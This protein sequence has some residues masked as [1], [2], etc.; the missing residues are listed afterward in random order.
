MDLLLSGRMMAAQRGSYIVKMKIIDP[1]VSPQ[2]RVT[3]A[4]KNQ[5]ALQVGAGGSSRTRGSLREKAHAALQQAYRR[6]H[7]QTANEATAAAAAA[8]DA[9]SCQTLSL[10]HLVAA[11]WW[12]RRR[13]GW[14]C[15][16][17]AAA[18]FAG[19]A[20]SAL[21]FRYRSGLALLSS[22]S[23]LQL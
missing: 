15:Q 6:A 12:R 4:I 1:K 10:P 19:S 8:T 17:A 9:R 20:V 23:A 21:D 11:T 14:A 5:E 22:F 18:V 13:S 7:Q 3:I 2:N 16:Q